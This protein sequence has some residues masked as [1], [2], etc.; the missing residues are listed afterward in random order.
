[1][2]IL[3]HH[4]ISFKAPPAGTAAEWE[5]AL[6]KVRGVVKVSIDAAKGD[7]FVEYDLALCCE[8]AIEKWMVHEGFV[9]DDHLMERVKRGWIHYTEENE[10][11]ALKMIPSSH[12]DVEDKEC[13]KKK[14]K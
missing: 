9:L 6:R 1:M 14:S 5:S 2:A 3:K 12:C 4:H 10:L 13:R 8:E 11:D 7:V